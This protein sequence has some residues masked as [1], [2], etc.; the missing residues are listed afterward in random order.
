MK[1]FAPVLILAALLPL[2]GCATPYG[3]SAGRL[4]RL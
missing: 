2:A 1:K 4:C 3:Y